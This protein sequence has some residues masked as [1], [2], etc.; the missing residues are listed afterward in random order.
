MEVTN[1]ITTHDERQ[2]IN[3]AINSHHESKAEVQN[4][5]EPGAYK[6][7]KTADPTSEV[8]EVK[9]RSHETQSVCDR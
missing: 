1:G 8:Q 9:Y 5:R 3:M 6:T 2:R 4:D 7:E